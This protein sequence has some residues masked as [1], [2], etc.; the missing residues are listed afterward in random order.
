M[1]GARDRNKSNKAKAGELGRLY[2][3]GAPFWL[4]ALLALYS[5]P[6][7]EIDPQSGS[8]QT[9]GLIALALIGFAISAVCLIKL[10]YRLWAMVQEVGA[11]TTPGKAVWLT[12]IPVFHLYWLFI[13]VCGLVVDFN[14]LIAR[15]GAEV[16]SISIHLAVSACCLLTVNFG[17]MFF[18]PLKPLADMTGLAGHLLMMLLYFQLQRAAQAVLTAEGS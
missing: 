15:R 12:F 11:R 5:P 8:W 2:L 9:L 7:Q 1:T 6:L 17:L 4:V 10:H 16:G 18:S 14:K 13:T 3:I